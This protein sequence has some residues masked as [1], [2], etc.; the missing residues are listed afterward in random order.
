MTAT[1]RLSG[2]R[3]KAW[4][5]DGLA[6]VEVR[7]ARTQLIS[8]EH[9]KLL[10][11]ALETLRGV[12]WAAWN[13]ALGRLLIS[14]DEETLG[15]DDLVE[16]VAAAES[17]HIPADR[18]PGPPHLD[19]ETRHLVTLAGDL[20][21]V[22]G[23]SVAR[24]LRM[25]AAP[26]ELAA[27]VAMV[28]HIPGLRARLRR[29]VG[30]HWADLAV[31]M[32]S[33]GIDA[34]GQARL[35]ALADAAMRVVLLREASAQRDTWQRRTAELPR[36]AGA[37]RA[38][39][40]DDVR[41]ATL[42]DGPVERYARRISTLTL[43]ASGAVALLPSGAR[44]AARILAAGSPVPAHAGREVYAGELGRLLARRDVL[45]RDPGALRRLDRVDTVV[46]DARALTRGRHVITHVAPIN[47]PAEAAW[48]A[49]SRL[50]DG[51]SGTLPTGEDTDGWAITALQHLDAAIPQ[52]VLDDIRTSGGMRGRCT[53]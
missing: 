39:S 16:L 18:A 49:A 50:V 36:E 13:A 11:K 42:P 25:P 40:L 9:G 15:L 17:D 14:Y 31:S 46:I 6:H 53:R 1:G 51:H 8:T 24:G 7:G 12:D 37:S 2:G 33:A 43:I 20:L 45:V 27:V 21:G 28:D 44:R 30:H 26:R 22:A 48:E 29:S 34:A 47:G 23:A 4:A 38:G 35:S 5:K 32:A 3:R 10:E 19:A 41:P 52:A